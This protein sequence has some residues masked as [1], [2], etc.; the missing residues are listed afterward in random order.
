MLIL[1]SLIGGENLA[2]ASLPG[3]KPLSFGN[4]SLDAAKTISAGE[5]KGTL[6]RSQ[7]LLSVH[8]VKRAQ[9]SH[10]V[11]TRDKANFHEPHQWPLTGA[12]VPSAGLA[13]HGDLWDRV[14]L[15]GLFVELP[16]TVDS[17]G[18]QDVSFSLSSWIFQLG[19]F[20]GVC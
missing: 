12:S 4:S 3:F 11:F 20:S 9:I 1:T 14:V 6:P 18:K 7:F 2:L 19:K 10:R 17:R 16:Y 15:D 13:G 8:C 5:I